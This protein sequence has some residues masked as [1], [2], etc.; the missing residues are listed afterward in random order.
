MLEQPFFGRRLKELRLERGL[1]Q[2]ALVGEELSTG[3][4]SRLESGARPPTERVV[5]YLAGKLGVPVCAFDD[6]PA[7]LAHVLA[8][9]TSG[10]DGDD[11]AEA[12]SEAIAAEGQRNPA[13]RWQ[14]LWLLA[15]I[16]NRLGQYQDELDHMQDLV[17]LADQLDTPELRTRARAQQARCMRA[18][19]DNDQAR[20]CAAEAFRIAQE[21][22]LSVRDTAP[23]LLVLVSAE[24]EAGRLP[25]ARAHAD[26]LCALVERAS[27]S[28]PVEAMWA[29]ATVRIRQGEPAAAQRLLEDA[30]R[31][32]DS[33]DDLRLWM[34]LRLAAASMHLQIVP[35]QTAEARRHLEEAETALAFV[36]TR[37]HQQEFLALQVHLAFREGRVADAMKLCEQLGENDLLLSFRDRARLDA[38]RSQ[39]L[40]LEGHFEEGIRRLRAL[41]IEADE[42]LNLDLA[43]EIWR[44][45]AEILTP[46]GN[47]GA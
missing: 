21:H 29:A 28:L 32:L 31:K 27:G 9:V 8:V 23:A 3:Y 33:H 7:G 22:R 42:A 15:R 14:G 30:L 45:L 25:E 16:K 38:I 2:A 12:L 19:G 20:A 36:G 35:P 46:G 10:D 11:T 5:T 41:A 26:D 43:A 40:I 18:L 37:L 44:T 24:A 47:T 39:L 34:R 1:S 17:R 4:L 6:A 13:L